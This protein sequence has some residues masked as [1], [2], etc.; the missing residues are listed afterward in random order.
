MPIYPIASD[1]SFEVSQRQRRDP[2]VILS[3]AHQRDQVRHARLEV[4][5]FL[6]AFSMDE[7][8][9]SAEVPVKR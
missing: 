5:D 4:E 3:P 8:L 2:E 9:R 6:A 7:V 1:L